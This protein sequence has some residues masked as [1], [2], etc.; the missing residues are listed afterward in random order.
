MRRAVS[1]HSEYNSMLEAHC[2][3]KAG[4]E[5]NPHTLQTTH[6]HAQCSVYVLRLVSEDRLQVVHTGT[7]TYCI[8]VVL[9]RTSAN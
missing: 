6:G 1:R 2:Y 7:K 9:R 4:R 8:V 3:V 5:C